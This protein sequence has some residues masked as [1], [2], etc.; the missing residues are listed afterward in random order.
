MEKYCAYLFSIS[1]KSMFSGSCKRI[2]GMMETD[3]I[4]PSSAD[5][6]M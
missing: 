4:F 1:E 2:A 6:C 3:K 5:S